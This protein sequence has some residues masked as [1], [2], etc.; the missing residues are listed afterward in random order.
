MLSLIFIVSA[1]W[2]NILWVDTSL[3]LGTLSW[4][5][6]DQFLLFLLNSACGEVTNTKGV[7][8]SRSTVLEAS[9]LIITLLMSYLF[10]VVIIRVINLLLLSYVV[11]NLKLRAKFEWN[12]IKTWRTGTISFKDKIFKLKKRVYMIT[13]INL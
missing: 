13:I 7:S 5:R 4:Y 8:T 3:H 6:D 1:H 12:T 11:W 2:N 9:T 10:L